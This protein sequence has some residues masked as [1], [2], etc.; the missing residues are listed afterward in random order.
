MCISSTVMCKLGFQRS[1]ANITFSATSIMHSLSLTGKS[2][3]LFQQPTCS[4]V[5]RVKSLKC[6]IPF[7]QTLA[8]NELFFFFSDKVSCS[9]GRPKTFNPSCLHLPVLRLQVGATTPCL[10]A[11]KDQ[12]QDFLYAR[13]VLSEHP[14][15]STLLSLKISTFIVRI[16][17]K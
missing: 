7:W 6:F 16:G 14:Q 13:Q 9:P 17:K 4:L 1:E 3:G 5:S 8:Y 2:L 15:P 10:Y 11:A 12:P